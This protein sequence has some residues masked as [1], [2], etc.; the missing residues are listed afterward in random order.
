MDFCYTAQA[1][2]INEDGCEAIL[3]SID[4]FHQHKS[5]ITD[6]EAWVG[7]GNRPINNWYIPKLKLMQSVVPNIWANGVAFQ[8]S[9]DATEHAHITKIKNPTCSGNNQ[10]YETQ[11]CRD[12]DCTDKLCWFDLATSI[13]ESYMDSPNESKDHSS[14]KIDVLQQVDSSADN[15]NNVRIPLAWLI[16]GLLGSFQ[17]YFDKALYLW[18]DPQALRPLRTFT[19]GHTAL[20]LN[21]DPSSKQMTIDEATVVYGIPDLYPALTDFI[22]H[23][24]PTSPAT[25]DMPRARLRS[26]NARE[27]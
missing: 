25:I 23:Y 17:N 12:L 21:C 8:Y 11:I 4:E 24:T 20:H 7:K 5:G 18:N 6:A 1:E 2:E 14:S 13:C 16:A 15:D 22:H 26:L 27:R 10:N 9:A 3:A 19:D